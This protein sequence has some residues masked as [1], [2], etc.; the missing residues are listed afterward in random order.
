[1]KPESICNLNDLKKIPFLTKEI[2][3]NNFDKMQAKD[4]HK[5]KPLVRYTGGSTGMPLKLVHDK[6]VRVAELCSLLRFWDGIGFKFGQ[7]NIRIL[8]NNFKNNTLVKRDYVQNSL[9][10]SMKQISKDNV[11]QILDYFGSF[12]P[13]M[14]RAYPSSLFLLAKFIQDAGLKHQSLNLGIKCIMTQSETLFDFQRA[15]IEDVF[16]VKVFDHYGHFEHAVMIAECEMQK[17]HY[18]MDYGIM[19][20]VDNDGNPVKT[21]NIGQIVGTSLHNFAMP[22]I[23]YKTGDLAIL[24][25]KLCSCGRTFPVVEK[26]IGRINDQIVTPDGR[27]INSAF[28]NFNHQSKYSSGI[29]LTQIIQTDINKITV[30]I[31]INSNYIES[32]GQKLLER[33]IA[34]IGKGIDVELELVD[35]YDDFEISSYLHNLNSERKFRFIIS[36]ISDNTY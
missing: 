2:I 14:I 30:K 8:K 17:K 3:R 11:P 4:V 1:M 31:M 15:L 12:N 20:L 19:E 25:D 6:N 27:Y 36:K 21:G 23:R 35:S 7:R 29:D 24:S 18:L 33:L 5:R 32:E 9:L 34:T 10:L 26:V 28:F 13:V 16:G 22:I